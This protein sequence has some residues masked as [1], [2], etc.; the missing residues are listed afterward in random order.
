MVETLFFACSLAGL[1]LALG[2][3][4]AVPWCGPFLA[5]SLT[6]CVELPAAMCGFYHEVRLLV[7]CLSLV[8][9][10]VV[11]WRQLA[12]WQHGK[13]CAEEVL[14]SL[15]FLWLL[16]F[17]AWHY[18]GARLTSHDEFFWGGFVKHLMQ[19]NSLWDWSS[20]LPRRDSVLLYPPMV[21]LLQS[22]LQPAGTYSESAI[23]LG[24]AAVL[25][26]CAGVVVHVARQRLSLTSSCLLG[27]IAFCLFRALG[28]AGRDINSYIF[29]LGDSLQMALYSSLGLALAC[30]RDRRHQVLLLVA[31]LPVLVLC[32]ASGALLALCLWGAWALRSLLVAELGKSRWAQLAGAVGLALPTL[33]FWL[34]WRAYLGAVIVPGL[35]PAA[36]PFPVDWQT[37]RHVLET[38][39]QAFWNRRTIVLPY[40]ERLL[41]LSYI[42][43]MLTG[44][45]CTL[46]IIFYRKK[47]TL[48]AG[49]WIAVL[50]LLAGFVGWFGVHVYVAIV[51][52]HPLEGQWFF[53]F[54]RYISV[55][56]CP[57]LLIMFLCLLEQ[58]EIWGRGIFRY[59]VNAMLIVLCIPLT[60]WGL[61]PA[62]DF[63]RSVAAMEQAAS[64]LEKNTPVGST[65]WLVTGQQ[66][67]IDAN[68][69]Q[70]FLMPDRREAP[71][72]NLFRFNPHGSPELDL[73]SGI[74]PMPLKERVQEQ[75]V[76]Y[77]LLWNW[78]ADFLERYGALLGLGKDVHPPVLL[79]L[80]NWRQGKVPFPER[81]PLPASGAL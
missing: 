24:E 75:K 37:V 20:V 59:G 74:L 9:A 8:S 18:A 76:D 69:C 62:T 79:R 56:L 30:G 73:Q 68:V 3:F 72:E 32:K 53:C 23:A 21:T 28:A 22:L 4:F 52:M 51:Y 67:Y 47:K 57:L 6:A 55:A 38:Y 49:N 78:P 63:P 61:I 36:E 42:S 45:L 17:F 58:G 39:M 5:V 80:D 48:D 29:A 11:L 81:C 2:R 65:Y 50:I 77:L 12:D 66:G 70:Y 44:I 31:A 15:L 71:V 26:S 19:E 14:P 46:G 40:G 16:C 35:P 13:S 33:V 10:A 25:L 60:I 41:F 27:I 34:L 43:V 1:G 7:A 64:I 54:E